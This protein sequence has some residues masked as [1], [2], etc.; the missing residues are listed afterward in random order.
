MT[1][2][3]KYDLLMAAGMPEVTGLAYRSKPQ[4]PEHG[5]K[6]WHFHII[7]T[8]RKFWVSEQHAHDL[9]T[10]AGLSWIGDCAYLR[11]TIEGMDKP[12]VKIEYAV[13]PD[14][15]TQGEGDTILDAIV[16]AVQSNSSSPSSSM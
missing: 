10:M 3:E 15:V 8:D 7:N 12:P 2:K 5:N 9:I 16:D 4:N 13:T 14:D 11:V 6:G 1:L